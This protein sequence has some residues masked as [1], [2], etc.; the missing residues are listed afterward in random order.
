MKHVDVTPLLKKPNL[1]LDNMKHY[2]SMSNV[3]FASKLLAWCLLEHATTDDLLDRNQSAYRPYRSTETALVLV[4]NDI[5]HALDRRQGVTL[6]LLDMS[7][8]FDTVD[9]D[10]LITRLEK[11]IEVT[12]SVIAYIRS[13]L[14]DRTQSV[15]IPGGA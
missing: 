13:Y 14:T 3:S 12:C 5:L 11:R 7:A 4:Q 10:I 15:K 8:A 6:V 1:D 2:R 9:H